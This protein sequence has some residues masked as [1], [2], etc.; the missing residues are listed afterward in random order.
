MALIANTNVSL[1]EIEYHALRLPDAQVD[2]LPVIERLKGEIVSAE[3]RL[4]ATAKSAQDARNR[5]MVIETAALGAKRELENIEA[6]QPDLAVDALL[7]DA[8]AKSVLLS[9]RIGPRNCARCFVGTSWPRLP[10][11]A[12]TMRRPP[13]SW[14][15]TRLMSSRGSKKTWPVQGSRPS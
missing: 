14:S 6:G 1:K 10:G 3:A 2:G 12:M 13:P 5:K 7:G 11:D 15:R 4:A 8:D 9:R